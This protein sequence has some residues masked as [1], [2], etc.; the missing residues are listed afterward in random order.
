M[1]ISQQGKLYYFLIQVG[2][3]VIA[4]MRLKV[5]STA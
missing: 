3:T 4:S 1:A 2:T 5:H